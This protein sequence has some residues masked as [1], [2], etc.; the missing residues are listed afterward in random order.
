MENM[1]SRASIRLTSFGK[2]RGGKAL[3]QFALDNGCGM[4]TDFIDY[5]ATVVRLFA[6]DRYG[7][8]ADVVLGFDNIEQY[9]AESPYFGC[10]VGRYGNRI[11]NA[12]FKLNGRPHKLAANNGPN[13]LHGGKKGFDKVVWNAR[14]FLLNGEP[15]VEFTHTSSDGDEGFPGNLSMTLRYSLTRKNSL[16]LEYSA[17]T[18]RATPVN[19]TN[20]SYFNL[21]GEGNGDILDHLLTLKSR[22]ITPVDENL[23]PTGELLGV[24]GTPFDF[25]KPHAIGE[26]V[27]VDN[28]QLRLANGY[29]HNFIL[30]SQ[31]GRLAKCAAVQESESGRQLEVWT[32]EPAVQ[33]YIG[34]FLEGPIGKSGRP[35]AFRNAFCLECQHYPDSPNQP[36]F[37]NTILKKG[38][39]YSQVTEYRFSAK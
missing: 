4:R 3:T 25:A 6:P 22:A 9:E 30:N 19:L 15:G 2:T 14:P 16:R 7:N 37:P 26:R 10:V 13:S 18:D 35:Y 32:T 17:T 34:N 28:G 8:S 23:I 20:H 39:V 1:N 11:A 12:E 38:T 24:K 33:L 36:K 27:N 5:G 31:S 21:K 29:D